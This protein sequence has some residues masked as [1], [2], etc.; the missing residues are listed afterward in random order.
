[1]IA[2][3]PPPAAGLALGT[4][5]LS[6][7]RDRSERFEPVVHAALDAGVRI[8]DTATAY[9]TSADANHGERMLGAALR[10]HPEG[11]NAFV[12]S[13]GGHWRQGDEFPIDGRPETLRRHVDA[14]LRALQRDTIDLYLL[15]WPDPSVPI[16]ESAGELDAL[17]TTGKLRAIGVSNVSRDQLL[18][19]VGQVRIDAVQNH[20]SVFDP[21]DVDVARLADGLDIAYFAHSPLTGREWGK[22]A[23]RFRSL[24]AVAAERG[25]SA[26]SLALAWVRTAGPRV[27]PVVGSTRVESVIDSMGSLSVTLTEEER[28]EL[29]RLA[30]AA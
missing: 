21:A 25:V 22:G 2:S 27:I 4:A 1:M 10:R 8:I 7:E 19:A 15:H 12:V 6:F 5:G 13:K 9:T 18:R 29:V 14:S 28:A 24:E 3:A 23:K 17:R 16:E 20:L 30:A 11:G 26:P